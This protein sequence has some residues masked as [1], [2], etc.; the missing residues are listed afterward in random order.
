MFYKSQLIPI[1][2]SEIK[3]YIFYERSLFER[4]P[5]P[6]KSDYQYYGKT[7]KSWKLL[8]TETIHSDFH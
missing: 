6:Y 1:E 3:T 5:A 8:E 7:I 4:L 2:I